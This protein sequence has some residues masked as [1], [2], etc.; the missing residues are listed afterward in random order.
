MKNIIQIVFLIVLAMIPIIGICQTDSIKSNRKEIFTIIEEQPSFP[1][2]KDAL[3][4]YISSEQRR[5][6]Y[7][8]DDPD[9]GTVYLTFHIDT[10]GTITNPK[11]IRGV[12]A[13]LDSVPVLSFL[14]TSRVPPSTASINSSENIPKPV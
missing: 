11:V 9:K 10:H 5:F 13:R 4:K 12:N 7:T 1:G 3:S 14:L 8:K 2:S 6:N